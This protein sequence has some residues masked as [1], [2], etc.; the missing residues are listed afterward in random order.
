MKKI[1]LV[2]FY[3][4]QIYVL[5]GQP[6]YQDKNIMLE[7]WFNTK[8]TTITLKISN[9]SNRTMYLYNNIN[10]FGNNQP[11]SYYTYSLCLIGAPVA[12]VIPWIHERMYF[13]RLLKNTSISIVVPKG[14]WG[15]APMPIDVE[16]FKLLITLEYLLLPNHVFIPDN[17]LQNYKFLKYI[18][19]R[20]YKI[21]IIKTPML[22][23]NNDEDGEMK[24]LQITGSVP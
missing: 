4:I 19:R 16:T 6:F 15:I 23:I 2:V 20:G 5:I 10:R 18:K 17:K 21:R 22:F 12:H 8:D 9:I 7:G 24:P 1:I 14:G 11:N 3:T 13:R